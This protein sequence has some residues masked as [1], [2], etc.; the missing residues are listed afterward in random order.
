[1][2]TP[3]PISRRALITAG[4]VTIAGAGTLLLAACSSSGA[5]DSGASDS[6]TGGGSPS[7]SAQPKSGT[8]VA[9]LSDIPVGGSISANIGNNPVLLA[10]P[11]AGKV[12]CFS[13]ICTHQGCVVSPAGKQFDCPCHGS[14]FDAAT[15]KVL[16]G[17]A[18]SP[19][20]AVAVKVSGG[21]VVTA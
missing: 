4:G 21:A 18:P 8:E 2:N 3:S 9:K 15:G 13:A 19:L 10:Q 5:S 7:S 14:E 16:Q 12:V 20:P 1:M 17:P 6:G 11:T